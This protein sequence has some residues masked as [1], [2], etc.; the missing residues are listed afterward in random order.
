MKPFTKHACLAVVSAAF[1][2][3]ALAGCG[4]PD[5]DK[6]MNTNTDGTATAKGSP[7]PDNPTSSADAYKSTIQN[8]VTTKGVP[9][10]R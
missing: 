10:S 5:N 7:P 3:T 1:I 9:K 8:Q 2:T 6:T 4:G